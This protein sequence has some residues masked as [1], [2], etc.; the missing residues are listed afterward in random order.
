[1]IWNLIFWYHRSMDLTTALLLFILIFTGLLQYFY[2][3]SKNKKYKNKIHELEENLKSVKS[4]SEDKNKTKSEG[5]DT[6]RLENTLSL[7]VAQMNQGIVYIGQNKTIIYANPYAER[8]MKINPSSGKPY[9]EAIELLVDGKGSNQLIDTVFSGKQVL[10]SDA[11]LVSQ[12]GK[13]AVS[14][15]IIPLVLNEGSNAVVLVFS[16]N[17]KNITRI[18]E[19]KA[20]FSAAAHELRTPLTTIHMSI[21][22]IIQQ[23]DSLGREKIISYLNQTNERVE[24]LTQLVNDF[25]NVSRIDQGRM[26]V[27]L[28]SFNMI[29]LTDQVIKEFSLLAK[30]R[31]L[32][33]THEPVE[34]S[35]RNVLADPVKTKEVLTNLISNSLKYTTQGGVTLSHQMTPTTLITKVTDSGNGITPQS[36][37][38]LFKG[39]F[40]VGAARLQSTTKG[41]GLGLYISKK[42]AGL[43]KGDVELVTSEPGKGTSFAFTLPL[44]PLK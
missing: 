1:M 31:N 44:A 28:K 4:E 29:E 18:Q 27:N 40:Q 14:G 7:I 35:Y 5:S 11:E 19:Q 30:E 39:F 25:L 20:F 3:G 34:A 37:R 21:L 36:Q 43:M 12:R 17:S 10:L 22:L 2:F 6:A 8:F 24:Y 15:Y 23:F 26:T 42:I 13:T 38:L 9:T 41:S 32:Y 16:D 33:L